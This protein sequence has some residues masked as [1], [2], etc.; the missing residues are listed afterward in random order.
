MENIFDLLVPKKIITKEEVETWQKNNFELPAEYVEFLLKYNGASAWG[1]DR[2]W[3]M[4]YEF[5][6][7]S[8]FETG[9]SMEEFLELDKI[10]EVKAEWEE[11]L[12]LAYEENNLTE[13]V[14]EVDKLIPIAIDAAGVVLIAAGGKHKGVVYCCD[15]GD[16]GIVKLA[17]NLAGFLKMLRVSR[18]K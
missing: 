17:D 5:K 14:V 2:S 11:G 3:G 15:R 8:G 4:D 6:T 10:L 12:Q 7:S 13:A 9:T 16:F 18:Y 1:K